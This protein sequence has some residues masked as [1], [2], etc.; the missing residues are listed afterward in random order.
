MEIEYVLGFVY[1]TTHKACSL[2]SILQAT[3]YRFDWGN[4]IQYFLLHAVICKSA[5]VSYFPLGFYFK[6]VS[7]I[8]LLFDQERIIY[9]FDLWFTVLEINS[10]KIHPVCVTGNE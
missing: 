3:P 9:Y 5:I 7:E 6:M 8:C 2:A 1:K 4:D 10:K